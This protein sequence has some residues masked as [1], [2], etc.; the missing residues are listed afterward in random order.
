MATDGGK[1]RETKQEE[2]IRWPMALV[3]QKTKW[4]FALPE[5]ELSGDRRG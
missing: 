1:S 4:R 3:K 5:L 2:D